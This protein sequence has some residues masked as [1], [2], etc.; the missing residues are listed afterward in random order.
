MSEMITMK[1][2]TVSKPNQVYYGNRFYSLDEWNKVLRD[3]A[4]QDAIESKEIKLYITSVYQLLTLIRNDFKRIAPGFVLGYVSN[5]S[6]VK[7]GYIEIET[8]RDINPVFDA[9]EMIQKYLY[10]GAKA[11]MMSYGFSHR[12]AA[13]SKFGYIVESRNIRVRGFGFEL[14][15]TRHILENCTY[16]EYMGRNLK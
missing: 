5:L 6:T 3:P 2:P 13:M 12:I 9:V 16:D 10:I 7:D 4:L 8:S 1:I 11:G 14:P 15:D